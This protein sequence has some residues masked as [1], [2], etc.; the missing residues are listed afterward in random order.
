VTVRSGDLV[1]G[2]ADGVVVVERERVEALLEAAGR[3]V[4]DEAARIEAIKKGNTA[5]RWLDSALRS[6]GVLKDDETL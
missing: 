6:A 4:E 3:K 2:D 5:A 1:V